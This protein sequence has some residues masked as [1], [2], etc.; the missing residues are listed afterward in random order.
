MDKTTQGKYA[1]AKLILILL[2][3]TVTAGA[4]RWLSQQQSA[5]NSQLGVIVSPPDEATVLAVQDP[6][7]WS[8]GLSGLYRIDSRSRVVDRVYPEYRFIKGLVVDSDNRLWIGHEEG[9]TVMDDQGRYFTLTEADGLPD[10][11]ITCLMQDS[12]GRIWA[13]TWK[14]AAC[15]D[16]QNWQ[17]LDQ[18][19][20]LLSDMVNCILEDSRGGFWFGSYADPQGGL[21][22]WDEEGAVV[23]TTKDR[24]PHT[25]ISMLME[26]QN[27]RVWA[28]CGHLQRGGAAV[29]RWNGIRWQV[30]EVLTEDEGLPGPK[31]RSVY[32]N[33]QGQF[34][35]GTELNGL[36]VSAG[37]GWRV[38]DRKDGLAGSEIKMM[39]EQPTGTYWLATDEGISVVT[40]EELQQ[41]LA[42]NEGE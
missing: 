27:G 15:W 41:A 19:N 8:G 7:I 16:G 17:V 18:R 1:P 25:S 39:V 23:Y 10:G 9:I 37:D 35:L 34:F 3:L 26:D 13:G 5:P 33:G 28:A 6:W 38:L 36:A 14:G 40:H 24:L 11:H 2:I 4:G 21:T 22:R 30:T 42:E 20:G 29:L 31:V 32:Q 12:Q